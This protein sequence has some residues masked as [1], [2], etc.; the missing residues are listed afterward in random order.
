MQTKYIYLTFFL[1]LLTIPSLL[2]AQKTLSTKSSQND[3]LLNKAE[4]FMFFKD[5]IHALPVFLK[6]DSLNPQ[7]AVVN[8]SIGVC[9]LKSISN[10]KK[11]IPYL[12]FAAGNIRSTMTE[13]A[14]NATEVPVEVYMNLARAYHLD[15]KLDEAIGM[16]E[17]YK[18]FLKKEDPLYK[19]AEVEISMCKIAKGQMAHPVKANIKNIESV[20]SSYP[21]YGPV[22]SADESVLIFTSRRP[23]GSNE[24]MT[25]SGEYY[26]DIYIS[27]KIDDKWTNPVSIGGN[28]NSSGHEASIGLSADGQQLFIYK[29]DNN[30]GN[31][32]VCNLNGDTWSTPVKLGSNINTKAWEPSA[33]LS[34]DGTTLYFVS[35]RKEGYGGRDIYKSRKL[36]DG[37]WGLSQNLG[38]SINSSYDEDG[39]FIHP[40]GKTLYFSSNG[41][42]SMGGFDIFSSTLTD[43]NTWSAPE[44]V[45]Y[46]INTTDDDIFY[47]LSASGKHAYYSTFKPEGKGEK[48]IYMIT[49][50]KPK[51]TPLT[52]L[53]GYIKM[54]AAA[55]A[56][57]RIVVT[58]NET[59]DLIGIYTPNSKTGKYLLIL[60][61]GKDY[62]VAVEADGHLFHSENIN[63]PLNSEYAEIHRAIELAPLKAGQKIILNNIF[64]NVNK[65]DLTK[66]S[67][68]E[69]DRI[70]R[71]MNQNPTLKI[72]IS[73]HTDS[74]A[75]DEYNQSLSERRAQSVVDYL[76]ERGVD[77]TRMVSKGFGETKPIAP[78]DTPENKQLNRRTEF[79]ILSY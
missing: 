24:K 28:I 67:Q 21:D 9:Y 76:T 63:V 33:S 27:Y 25:P 17:K 30:D 73:A 29:D 15:Y 56:S 35:D 36:P 71:T 4:E 31:I 16:F 45:G 51:E 68:T 26:E 64:F 1:L 61:P 72:Q 77:K 47:V 75:S 41:P 10:K 40:D 70:F 74:D 62:N 66:N 43:I 60:P 18:T 32:Y 46:P 44:N 79:E 23:G 13:S 48:D 14:G 54:D 37:S 52:V 65:A 42:N 59:G 7:N 8:Y 57:A 20:N 6:L 2:L 38:N 11:A 34:A 50:D 12:E 3:E 5:Y 22:I 19:Q 49:L 78:N 69:L 58:D 53:S 55:L 39:P